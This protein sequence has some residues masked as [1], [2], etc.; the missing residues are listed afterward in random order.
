MRKKIIIIS[1]AALTLLALTITA[2]CIILRGSEKKPNA[3]SKI[4]VYD[5]G[6]GA[7]YTPSYED[8]LVGC[9]NGLIPQS[10]KLEPEALKA[11][12][13]AEDTRLRYI[14]ESR[15]GFEYL[16]ADLTVNEQ[17]PYT[18]N[19]SAE[20]REAVK[21]ALNVSLTYDGEPFNAPICKVSA[22]KT[23]ECPPYSPSL[24]LPCDLNAKGF[25]SSASFTPEKVRA[26]LGGGNLSY[27]FVEWFHNPVYSDNGTL[28]FIDLGDMR[29]TGETLRS[30][31]SLRSTAIKV[32]FA[33][34]RFVFKCTGWGNNR[35][36]SINAANF[37]AKQG[38]TAEEILMFFY[39]DAKLD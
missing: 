2:L 15:S 5:S 34:D 13:I 38:K 28:L 36:M 7:I 29:V 11:I 17:A 20:I 9:V 35:G 4:S 18:S 21:S 27:N 23:E 32:E 3:P 10:G 16:G 8:F 26:A 33:E 31:L 12:A 14:M 6:A 22:G 39:P 30:A 19:A 37:M 24:E 1:A 25:S